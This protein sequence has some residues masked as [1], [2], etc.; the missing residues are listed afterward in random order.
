[1]DK[2]MRQVNLSLLEVEQVFPDFWPQRRLAL[3]DD[4]PLGPC[5][6]F[7]VIFSII[8]NKKPVTAPH[9]LEH[10]LAKNQKTV[11]SAFKT[12]FCSILGSLIGEKGK[13]G[14]VQN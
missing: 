5:L 4:G 11:I 3:A 7:I 1:M 2:K 13:K 9:S 6:K 10:Q 12:H 8:T 14:T